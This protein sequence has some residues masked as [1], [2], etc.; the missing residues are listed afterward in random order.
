MLSE[1][2]HCMETS[3]QSENAGFQKLAKRR[4]FGGLCAEVHRSSQLGWQ[5]KLYR[6]EQV[7]FLRQ[8]GDTG[9]CAYLMLR[10]TRLRRLVTHVRQACSP[11]MLKNC[12]QRCSFK[13][14]S[15]CRT[16]SHVQLFQA[17]MW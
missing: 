17:S 5:L 16:A 7:C 11:N 12:S 1:I 8:L 15:G 6:A 14:W 2:L 10:C 9:D 13:A 3:H 4:W